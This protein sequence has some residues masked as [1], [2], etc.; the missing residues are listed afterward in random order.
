[1][2]DTPEYHERTYEN[3]MESLVDKEIKRQI[4]RLSAKVAQFV[5]PV[6]VATYALNRLPP[7]YAASQRGREQQEKQALIKYKEQIQTTVQMAIAAVQRDPLRI[8]NPLVEV[9]DGDYLK[10]MKALKE[11]EDWLNKL[12]LLTV[13]QIDWDNLLTTVKGAFYRA[14]RSGF[15]SYLNHDE[16]QPSSLKK[17]TNNPWR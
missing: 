7:L 3:V 5:D 12:H 17:S 14:S 4:S 1:M 8:S 10:A 2:T 9:F 15:D 6:D 13:R 11:L 16:V